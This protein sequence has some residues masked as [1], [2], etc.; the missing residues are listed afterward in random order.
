MSRHRVRAWVFGA[1]LGCFVALIWFPTFGI[2][3]WF[4]WIPLNTA[5]A[6]LGYQLGEY[7]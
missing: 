6:E 2:Y 7:Y 1:V 3:S 4:I 5:L